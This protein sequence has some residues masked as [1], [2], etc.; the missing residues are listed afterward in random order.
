MAKDDTHAQT[1][2]S[3][4]CCGAVQ[5]AASR[6]MDRR[7]QRREKPQPWIVLKMT[8]GF[9]WGIIG[10]ASY[11]YI[12]RFCVPMIRKNRGILGG[13]RVGS[14]YRVLVED[15]Q[16]LTCIVFSSL[17]DHILCVVSYDDVGI[18]SGTF[19]F[20]L[21]RSPLSFT[22]LCSQAQGKHRM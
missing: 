18:R 20:I 9:A 11:V 7:T 14:E 2:T 5:E 13:R 6:S 8:I 17:F 15:I 12:G 16:Y 22:S 19:R 4:K 1:Q 3:G 10:Y 21:P